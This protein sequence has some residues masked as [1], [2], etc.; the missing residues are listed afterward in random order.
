MGIFQKM[1][2]SL[3]KTRSMLMD[4]VDTALSTFVRLDE[5]MLEELED[6]LIM[7]DMGA[8][9]ASQIVNG[10]RDRAKKERAETPEAVKALI[11][12]EIAAILEL[13][14]GRFDPA[15]PCILLVV[16][17][18]GVG[19]TTSIG[20]LAHMFRQEGKSVMLA[21]ADTFR[22]AAVDQLEIW[23]ARNGVAIIKQAE[24]SDPGAVIFD[25]VAAAKARG[26]DVLICDTAGRLHNKKNLMN[27][28]A[29]LTK[30]IAGNYAEANVETLLVLDAT[31]G[32]NALA[33]ART[34]KEA[35]N[36]SGII[37]TKLDGTAKGGI[38]V[39]IKQ[40]LGLPVRFVGVGEGI[41]DLEAFDAPS[42]AKAMFEA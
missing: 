9:A 32:Q 22:A 21:A 34:F 25:A 19:K 33:Q 27:E 15:P 31:T 5:D 36:V 38:V 17:V 20:K 29:K 2:Q 16:G 13:D 3:S 12:Q 35:A 42:F 6:A 26:T 10:V 40:E 7:A 37:L 14:A 23:A 30:I 4:S 28:L 8:V 18:N 1:A 11:A 24:G 41:G 39:A